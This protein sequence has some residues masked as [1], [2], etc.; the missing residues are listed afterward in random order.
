MSKT[1]KIF[2]FICSTILILSV[3]AIFITSII[4]YD[5][6]LDENK[7]KKHS[8]I[9][10]IYSYDGNLISEASQK[11]HGKYVKIEELNDYTKN[12]FVAIEDKRFYS[13]NGI[14][15]KRILGATFKNLKSMSFKEGASTITQQLI[16]NTHLT[17]EKTIK[18]KLQEIKLASQLERRCSKD[19]ILELYLNTIYFGQGAYGIEDASKVYFN[20]SASSLTLNESALLAGIIKAPSTYSPINAYDLAVNRK[21]LVLKVMKN[22]NYITEKEYLSNVNLKVDI[23]NNKNND[24]FDDYVS[25]VMAEFEKLHVFKP[26]GYKKIKIE[27]YLDETLQKSIKHFISDYDESK[28]VINSKLCGITAFYGDNS[29]LKRSPASCVKPW[30]VYAPMINDNYVKESSVV[31]DEYIN[32]GGYTPKNFDNKY[33]GNVTVKESL[34]KSLNIPAVKLLNGYGIERANKY[35]SKMAVD[36]S[37][38]SLPCALGGLNNGLTLI[39]LCNKYSVFN[40]DG[41][42]VEAKAIK[43]V[44]LD[45]IKIYFH[46][47]KKI[48]VFSPQ[49]SYIINDVLKYAVS[50]GNSK[51]LRSLPFEVCAKTGTNGN[52]NGNIDALSIAYTSDSIIGVWIGNLSGKLLPNSVTGSNQPTSISRQILE[53]LY[54]DK[55]PMPFSKPHDIIEEKIDLDSLKNDGNEFISKTG[56]TFYYI[57]GTQPTKELSLT[58]QIYNVNVCIKNQ[59]V[60][61]KFECKNADYIEIFREFNG[62]LTCVYKG[63][64]T[65]NFTDKLVE[66]GKYRYLIKAHSNNDVYTFQTKTILFNKNLL[67][68]I[69]DDKWLYQ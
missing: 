34:A 47:P 24:C 26:Y 31:T 69:K 59:N 16:K 25:M 13:H 40:N 54:K 62:S 29:N 10:E 46:S 44:Y 45:G 33:N 11:N 60:N 22:C 57:N 68:V 28:I 43:C 55:S 17:S 38:E 5:T 53:V 20:K 2:L 42:Y 6:R 61:L 39:E 9:I 19:K 49:T 65:N 21:N 51:K 30:L 58:P 67:D 66:F 64:T 18:R 35:T 41:K 50:N 4:L 1:A 56:E 7:L 15:L 36:L 12:A 37:R 32:I 3:S 52:E 63:I 14:D 48:E 8:Q 23:T 27:T